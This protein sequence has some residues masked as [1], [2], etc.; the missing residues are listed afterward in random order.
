MEFPKAPG[1]PSSLNDIL[2]K[3]VERL[4]DM[5]ERVFS[6][7]HSK[8]LSNYR[9]LQVVVDWIISGWSEFS[10]TM[11]FIWVSNEAASREIYQL[12]GGIRA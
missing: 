2:L 6:V 1:S 5:E 8:R 11:G 9:N 12:I 7:R 10:A 4:D 3:L